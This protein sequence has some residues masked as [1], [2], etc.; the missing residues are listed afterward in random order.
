MDPGNVPDPLL[1]VDRLSVAFGSGDSAHVAVHDVSLTIG[2]R[3][4]VGLV[5]ESGSGKSLTCRAVLRLVPPGGHIRAGGIQFDGRDVADLSRPELQSLRAHDI[6]M[7]FQDPFSSLNP[8]L[9]IGKQMIET[10]RVNAGLSKQAAEQRAIDLLT[11][12]EIPNPAARLKAYPHELSGGMRQRVMIALAIASNPKLLIADEPTTAL[13]VSTQAQVLALLRNLTQQRDMSVLLVSHDFGVIAEMCDRV[14]VMY[15]GFVVE[16]GTVE[17]VYTNPV[18]P[19]SK[20]LLGAVPSL[21]PPEGGERRRGIPGPPL[22]TVP[23]AGGCPFEPRCV[24]ARP[25]CRT[26]DMRLLAFDETRSTACPFEGPVAV[27]PGAVGSG[28]ETA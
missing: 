13:D 8:T 21:H 16:T 15:G 2:R 26:V 3:E 23:Y 10:L 1:T 5:G 17:D 9:R 19:Y 11:Q 14:V 27:S 12:V 4:V 25:E 18:H 24:F 6:G 7:I 22:G 20:A 28:G